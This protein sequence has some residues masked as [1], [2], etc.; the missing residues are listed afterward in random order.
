MDVA[1]FQLLRKVATSRL[2][3]ETL[4]RRPQGSDGATSVDVPT[5]RERFSRRRCTEKVS[6]TA[7]G[8]TG[9][10][11]LQNSPAKHYVV[12]SL[13]NSCI[14]RKRERCT[15]GAGHSERAGKGF[16]GSAVT[17]KRCTV[18]RIW[19]RLHVARAPRR[20]NIVPPQRRY[21]IRANCG[22]GPTWTP[23]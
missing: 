2:G 18:A 10:R 14:F 19:K 22:D 21:N 6:P 15:V 4:A 12:P 7:S 23:F 11:S 16:T 17:R 9:Q 5:F 1:T 3:S 8:P 20:Y 13:S